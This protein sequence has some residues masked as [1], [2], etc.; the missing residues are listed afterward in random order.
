MRPMPDDED[1][2]V[3]FVALAI[4]VVLLALGGFFG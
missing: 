3:G 4:V 2:N 1:Y